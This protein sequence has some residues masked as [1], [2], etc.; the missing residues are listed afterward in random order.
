MKQLNARIFNGSKI[1]P[2]RCER[3]QSQLFEEGLDLE[4]YRGIIFFNLVGY[5]WKEY[6]PQ[7]CRC[8]A[9][10]CERKLF[11]QQS[12]KNIFIHTNTVPK[13]LNFAL[14]RSFLVTS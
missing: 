3:S 12:E 4:S 14:Q 9:I 8:T 2:L 7:K 11:L 6:F 5:P 13:N 10:L 1:L